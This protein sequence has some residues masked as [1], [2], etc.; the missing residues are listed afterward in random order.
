M[1]RNKTE[2]RKQVLRKISKL[3][4]EVGYYKHIEGVGWVDKE[5]NELYDSAVKL[6]I[7]RE[8]NEVYTH[9]VE[10]GRK[11][12]QVDD[13]HGLSKASKS[14]RHQIR[15]VKIDNDVEED[16]ESLV[17]TNFSMKKSVLGQ[18]GLTKRSSA[19]SKK[20]PVEKP[21]HMDYPSFLRL[22]SGKRKKKR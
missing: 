21:H 13:A 22:F 9:S 6:K 20:G 8:F 10:I 5:K 14:T 15:S 16:L 19:I 3:G 12:R 4:Y 18:P 7:E 2:E 1:W 17:N 11:K